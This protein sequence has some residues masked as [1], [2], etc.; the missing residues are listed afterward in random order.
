MVAQQTA[1]QAPE[2]VSAGLSGSDDCRHNSRGFELLGDAWRGAWFG[3][4]L[5]GGFE[6]T[7]PPV[8][9]VTDELIA[10]L[11]SAFLAGWNE[12]GEGYNA[13]YPC[14]AKAEAL[15]KAN[16]KDF[17]ARCKAVDRLR[18]DLEALRVDAE[19]YRWLRDQGDSCQW[20]NIIRVD[21]EDYPTLDAAIDAAMQP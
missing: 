8:V 11:E 7:T 17:A 19:R 20:M 15:I 21:P 13:E 9:S 3:F 16:A 14:T 10:E 1:A 2:L 18:A 12:S 5:V 4:R 6:M